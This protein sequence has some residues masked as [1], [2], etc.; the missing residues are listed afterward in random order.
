MT[1]RRRK[2]GSNISNNMSN[3]PILER[4]L[5]EI[6]DQAN[7]ITVQTNQVG[8]ILDQANQ[9][10]RRRR[11]GSKISNVSTNLILDQITDQANQ[12]SNQNNQIGQITD[13]AN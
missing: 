3:Y 7:Q 1:I 9:M 13:Q 11:N 2:N 5:D 12:I 10:V 8:L 6:S 4:I